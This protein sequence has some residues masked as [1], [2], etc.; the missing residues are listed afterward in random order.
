MTSRPS[1]GHGAWLPWFCPDA[2]CADVHSAL[3]IHPHSTGWDGKGELSLD[4]RQ[5]DSISLTISAPTLFTLSCTSPS[6]Q[7]RQASCLSWGAHPAIRVQTWSLTMRLYHFF[8]LILLNP[9][10]PRPS[11]TPCPLKFPSHEAT[12]VPPPSLA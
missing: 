9:F 11:H 2:A 10:H 5:S 12:A 6:C 3:E 8:L 7:S 4:P 1:A